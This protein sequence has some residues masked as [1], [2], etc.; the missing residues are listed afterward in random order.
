MR[1]D[2]YLGP[3]WLSRNSGNG[4]ETHGPRA[5]HGDRSGHEGRS[6]HA[7]PAPYGSPPVLLPYS[8]RSERVP[9]LQPGESLVV[10]APGGSSSDD[11]RMP[12]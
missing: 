4:L 6:A 1:D 12:L 10:P 5:Y 8:G 9:V 3:H 11:S 7:S 2:I